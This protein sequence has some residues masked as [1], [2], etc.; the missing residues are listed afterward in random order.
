[1]FFYQRFIIF[2]LFAHSIFS[3]LS[4]MK[5]SLLTIALLLITAIAFA[6]WPVKTNHPTRIVPAS[7]EG[8]IHV[9]SYMGQTVGGTGIVYTLDFDMH[10]ELDWYYPGTLT[11]NGWQYYAKVAV[12]GY[13]SE[14][15]GWIENKADCFSQ[16]GFELGKSETY[17]AYYVT[18]SVEI[19][20]SRH[21]IGGG[22]STVVL[23]DETI[24][25]LLTKFQD[26]VVRE[27][28]LSIAGSLIKDHFK[29]ERA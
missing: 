1:M 11:I 9:D 14:E 2:V 7:F 24:G 13:C 5:R 19:K 25:G 10:Q 15:E 12:N 27:H 29:G 22:V 21:Y 8:V 28:L 4:T 16:I 17:N 18:E 23:R 26:P 3:Y 20:R 6:R